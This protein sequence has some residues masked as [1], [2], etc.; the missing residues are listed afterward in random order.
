M[1]ISIFNTLHLTSAPPLDLCRDSSS[2]SDSQ[3]CRTGDKGYKECFGKLQFKHLLDSTNVELIFTIES[4]C[5][6]NYKVLYLISG[7]LL[8]TFAKQHSVG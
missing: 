8:Q 5:V 3:V 1:I 6:F 2:C 7:V 4:D